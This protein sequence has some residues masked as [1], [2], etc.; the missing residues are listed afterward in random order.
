V[1]EVSKDVS[2]LLSRSNLDEVQLEEIISATHVLFRVGRGL[3]KAMWVQEVREGLWLFRLH[4]TFCKPGSG[5]FGRIVKEAVPW[6]MSK[7]LAFVTFGRL[8]HT[9]PKLQTIDWTSDPQADSHTANDLAAQPNSTNGEPY[10]HAMTMVFFR[11]AGTLL[12][13]WL[14]QQ[15]RLTHATRDSVAAKWLPAS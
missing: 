12:L 6:G 13:E 2:H 7:A 3:T 14:D 9:Y 15:G 10:S 1:I 5:I 8:L 11:N 4:T